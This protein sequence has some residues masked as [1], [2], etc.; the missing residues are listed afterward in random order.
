MLHTPVRTADKLA[1]A[2]EVRQCTVC[3]TLRLAVSESGSFRYIG[4]FWTKLKTAFNNLFIMS[5]AC[6]RFEEGHFHELLFHAV[7]YVFYEKM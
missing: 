4:S 1:R 2:S 3:A 7:R 6:A 5:E